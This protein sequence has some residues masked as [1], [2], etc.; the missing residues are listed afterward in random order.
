[1][2]GAAALMSH[3]RFNPPTSSGQ[4]GVVTESESTASSLSLPQSAAAVSF[5]IYLIV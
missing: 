5:L 1:M 4:P 3:D 2:S